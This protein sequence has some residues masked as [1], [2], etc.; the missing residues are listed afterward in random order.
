MAKFYTYHCKL[1]F[2]AINVINVMNVINVIN[3]Y[4]AIKVIN[5]HSLKWI[6]LKK[7]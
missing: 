6:R 5:A 2:T 7:Y 3:V 1:K 4:Q